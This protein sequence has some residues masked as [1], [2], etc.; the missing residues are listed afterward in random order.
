MHDKQVWDG[1]GWPHQKEWSGVPV[2]LLDEPVKQQQRPLLLNPIEDG[3]ILVVGS[4]G[5]GRTNFLLTFGAGL[6]RSF[7]PD[8]IHFHMLDFGGHQLG[9]AFSGFPHIAGVY[10]ALETERIR[11]LLSTLKGELE[12]RRR[13]FSEVGAVSLRGYRAANPD[14]PPMPLVLTMI[15]NF[16]GFYDVFRDEIGEWNRLLREGGSYGL[17][18]VLTADRIPTGRTADLIQTRIALPLTD[19]TWYSL[20]LGSRPDLATYDPHPGRGFINTKP[21][22]ELQIAVPMQGTPEEQIADLQKLGVN[23]SKAWEGDRPEPVRILGDNVSFEEVL[24]KGVFERW[25]VREDLKTWIGL[26]HIDLMPVLLDLEDVGSSLLITGPPESG[27]TT[28]LATI[29]LSFAST[30]HPERLRMGFVFLGRKENHPF[31]KFEKLPHCFGSVGTL[32]SFEKL[33]TELEEDV[34]G[35]LADESSLSPKRSHLTIFID[36]YHVLSARADQKLLGRLEGLIRRGQEAGIT[37]F[38]TVP[39]LSLSGAGD[40]VLRTLRSLKSGLWLV[41][42]DRMLAQTVG[43]TIPLQMRS[44]QL[45]QGR[46]YLYHPGAQ[47]MLQVAT[48]EDVE[49]FVRKF[50]DQLGNVG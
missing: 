33:L 39:N 47:V 31:E 5:T 4:P 44:K 49:M 20:I 15:N 1:E 25:P 27:K 37:L 8:W 38:I 24:P 34:E 16:S 26:D 11:R 50:I 30:H 40:G 41:S 7:S 28:A 42:T 32:S 36:D 35:R 45:P 13:T 46:G 21:P 2:A 22:A 12:E 43:L 23:M 6:M 17:S 3:N 9:S 48:C 19:R 29:A 10:G 14:A 18:F